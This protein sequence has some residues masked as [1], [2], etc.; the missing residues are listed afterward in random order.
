MMSFQQLQ[1]HGAEDGEYPCV[2][3]F[4]AIED[5]IRLW[6]EIGPL[7]T[8]TVLGGTIDNDSPPLMM[9]TDLGNRV[10]APDDRRAWARKYVKKCMEKPRLRRASPLRVDSR[11]GWFVNDLFRV[12]EIA[13]ALPTPSTDDDKFSCGFMDL[14]HWLDHETV[15]P[16]KAA[17]V[18]SGYDPIT[19]TL[20]SA[21]RSTNEEMTQE[22]FRQLRALFEGAKD[23]ERSLLGWAGYAKAHNRK[24]HSWLDTWLRCNAADTPERAEQKQAK[25]ERASGTPPECKQ[26][27]EGSAKHSMDRRALCKANRAKLDITTMR[28]CPR[29]ILEHWDMLEQLHPKSPDG[30]QVLRYLKRHISDDELPVLKTVQNKLAELREKQ[31]IP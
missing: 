19:E 21:E 16:E 27:Q 2:S 8:P 5:V 7:R 12:S 29:L 11:L 20:D 18:L 14:G 31:L 10:P 6:D 1:I 4:I 9:V 17:M 26:V 22:D 13:E 15:A 23:K 25:S 28:G 24:V 30:R 3:D